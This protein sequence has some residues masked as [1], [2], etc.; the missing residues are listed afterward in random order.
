MSFPAATGAHPLHR[1]LRMVTV[2]AVCA[3]CALLTSACGVPQVSKPQI[4]PT[5]DVS[6]TAADDIRSS[7]LQ[8][9]RD[10][11]VSLFFLRDNRL[12]RRLQVITVPSLTRS[13]DLAQ[14]VIDKLV[15]GPTAAERTAGLQ[16]LVA[17]V[18]SNDSRTPIVINLVAN[19]T[20]RVDLGRT[21]L[22][23]LPGQDQI[24]ALSQIVYT[25]T[26]LS[27]VGRVEFLSD[28]QPITVLTGQ[29]PRTGDVY[30]SLFEC[31]ERGLCS[32]VDGGDLPVQTSE[33][34]QNFATTTTVDARAAG[35][36][37]GSD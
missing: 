9:S 21:R 5:E 36:S 11:T 22:A 34:E 29:G 6:D 15:A 13:E 14:D 4:I 25:L 33:A 16:S 26:S 32:V 7:P 18:A 28:T 12:V 30:A 17:R 23:E 1:L 37:S 10:Q 24:L 19:G 2:G 35:G 27:G 31:A 20:V 8:P 3:V